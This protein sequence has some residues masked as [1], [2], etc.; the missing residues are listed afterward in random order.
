MKVVL[1]ASAAA[2]WFVVEG[3]EMK[4]VRSFIAE[5]ALT[6]VAPD[7]MLVELANVLRFAGS[8]TRDDVVNAVRAIPAIGVKVRSF[9]EVVEVAAGV[10]FERGLTIY[11][12]VYAALAEVEG[13]KLVTYDRELL[14]K[15]SY[16]TTAGELLRSHRA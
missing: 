3:E 10:A 16:A 13:A 14:E 6:A 12:A 5:G 8:L 7:L 4:R 9:L 1:D 15:L 11:D 2:K